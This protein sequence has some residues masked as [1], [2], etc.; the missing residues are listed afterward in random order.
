MAAKRVLAAV[1]V[2]RANMDTGHQRVTVRVAQGV[3][4]LCVT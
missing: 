3:K 4:D 1:V 2:T